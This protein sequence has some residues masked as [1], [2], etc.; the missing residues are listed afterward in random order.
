MSGTDPAGDPWR[1]AT[2][3]GS[4]IAE[5]LRGHRMSL[6]EKLAWLEQMSAVVDNL[7]K[8]REAA[9]DPEATCQEG[10]D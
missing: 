3:E 9:T 7:A 8:D 10:Q 5:L 1:H 2:W 6:A 4:E